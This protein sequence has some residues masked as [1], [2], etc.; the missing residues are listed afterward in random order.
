MFSIVSF[1]EENAVE[2]V[3]SSWVTGVEGKMF[4]FWPTK[5]EQLK[6]NMSNRIKRLEK[7]SVN[8]NLIACEVKAKVNSYEQ[9]RDK[10]TEISYMTVT[11]NES[12]VD[13]GTIEDEIIPPTDSSDEELPEPPNKKSKSTLALSSMRKKIKY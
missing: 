5:S 11:E 2:G 8:W 10:V 9:M 13:I 1:K 7:P 4:C 12:D 3:P 6:L